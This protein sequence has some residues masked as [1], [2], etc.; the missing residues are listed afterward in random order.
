MGGQSWRTHRSLSQE[1]VG[2]SKYGTEETGL[3]SNRLSPN[4]GRFVGLQEFHAD[5]DSCRRSWRDPRSLGRKT[6]EAIGTGARGLFTGEK[7]TTSEGV[8]MCL[9]SVFGVSQNPRDLQDFL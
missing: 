8:R 7:P 3:R 5:S 4:P 1:E 2:T 9:I 6:C